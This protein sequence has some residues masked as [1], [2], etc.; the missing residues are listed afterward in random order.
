MAFKL[1]SRHSPKSPDE[2]DKFIR[3]ELPDRETEPELFNLVV[4]HMMHGNSPI[5][6]C[7]ISIN[8]CSFLGPCGIDNLDSTCMLNGKCTKQF[9]KPFN[10]YTSMKKDG[11]PKYQRSNRGR[12]AMV[13]G[14]LLDNQWVV[15]YNPYLLLKYNAHINVE[16]CA[17]I[18]SIKYLFKYM[19]KVRFLNNNL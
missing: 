1:V 11:Y 3:A 5:P 14:K 10:D 17:T 6:K 8:F 13:R 2:V 4:K 15:P 19:N 7:R 16:I 18:K 9:P 12:T